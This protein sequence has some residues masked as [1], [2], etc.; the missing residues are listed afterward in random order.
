MR[1]WTRLRLLTVFAALAPAGVARADVAPPPDYVDP[2]KSVVLDASCRRCTA[3][4]FKDRTCHE[5][6]RAAGLTERCHG[7]GYAM[8]CNESGAPT[9]APTPTLDLT[10][11]PDPTPEPP[12]EPAPTPAPEPRT[13]PPPTSS[14]RAAPPSPFPGVSEEP[15]ETARSSCSLADRSDGLGALA[16]AFGVVAVRRRRRRA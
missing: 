14:E 16:L 15:P 13:P 7:W 1:P 9:P 3:P 5:E 10:P 2:C 6:A 4:E 8:Y 11:P 12:P